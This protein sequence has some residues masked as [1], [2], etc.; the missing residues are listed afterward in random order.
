MNFTGGDVPEQLRYGQVSADFFALFG[1]RTLAG[2]TFTADEDAPGGPKVAVLSRALWE[3]RFQADPDIVGRAISLSGDPYTIVGVLDAFDFRSSARRRR[4]GLPFQLDPNTADQGHY[5]QV[6]GRLK[7]GV[8]LEQANARLAAS[9]SD[10]RAKFPNALGPNAGFGVQ[11]IREVLV[12]NVRSS[13]LVLAGA[14]GLRAAHR[15]RERREPAAGPGD[16]PPAR[17]GDPRGDGRGRADGSS[18]SC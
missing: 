8:R 9:A 3:S 17:N 5:F 10:Y 4:S 7:P 12:R 15:V 18:G 13:L 16:G 11:P 2:R 14:V 6:L 1:A